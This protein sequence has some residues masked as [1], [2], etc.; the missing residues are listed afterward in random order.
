MS[1]G[2]QILHIKEKQF[3]KYITVHLILNVVTEKSV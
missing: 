3:K 1:L 2:S